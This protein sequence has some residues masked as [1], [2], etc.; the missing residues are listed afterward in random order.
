VNQSRYAQPRLAQVWDGSVSTGAGG[1]SASLDTIGA[2]NV[3]A[4]GNTS[5]PSTLTF[6]TSPDGVTWYSTGSTISANGDFHGSF[7]TGAQ[8]VRLKS[9][10]DVTATAWLSAK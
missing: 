5:G 9:G 10:S 1:T 2:W 7:T 4:F 3:T 8:F 6:Q